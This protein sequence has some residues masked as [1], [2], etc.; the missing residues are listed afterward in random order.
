M[1]AIILHLSKKHG[2]AFFRRVAFRI[3]QYAANTDKLVIFTRSCQNI[4]NR[5]EAGK[6]ITVVIEWMSGDIE[7]CSLFLPHQTFTR[8]TRRDFQHVLNLM[9]SLHCILSKQPHLSADTISLTSC[10]ILHGIIQRK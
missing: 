3:G 9:D 2:I 6:G 8:R 1:S 4:R 7:S 5:Q 10:G